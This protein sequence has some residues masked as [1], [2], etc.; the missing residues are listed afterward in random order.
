[1]L[2]A[3]PGRGPRWSPSRSGARASSCASRSRATRVRIAPQQLAVGLPDLDPVAEEAGSPC[4]RALPR[5]HGPPA[6]P[7][8]QLDQVRMRPARPALRL[9]DGT[10]REAQQ[11]GEGERTAKTCT[12]MWFLSRPGPG[13]RGS[14]PVNGESL[15]RTHFFSNGRERGIETNAGDEIFRESYRPSTWRRTC[16]KGASRYGRHRTVR[17]IALNL[18]ARRNAEPARPVLRRPEGLMRQRPIGR[19]S[20]P[21]STQVFMMPMLSKG[22]RGDVPEDWPIAYAEGLT[23]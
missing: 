6:H 3:R 14:A 8:L 15:C 10:R 13:H 2:A 23:S 7:S 21:S 20:R 1:M 17:L 19:R 22:L 18:G 11:H 16:Y 9:R 4:S 12:F 5:H